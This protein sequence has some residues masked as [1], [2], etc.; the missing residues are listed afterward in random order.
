MSMREGRTGIATHE[1][2]RIRRAFYPL[3][4]CIAALAA[5]PQPAA[6]T[7]VKLAEG[8]GRPTPVAARA[9]AVAWSRY[10]PASGRFKLVISRGGRAAEARIKSRLVP[11]DVDLGPDLAGKTVAV[12][13]RCRTEPRYGTFLPLPARSTGRGCD[14]YKYNLATQRETR[15]DAASQRGASEYAPSVWGDRLAFASVRERGRRVVRLLWR[16]MRSGQAS[17]PLPA[18]PSGDLDRMAPEV[19]SAD[20]YGKRLAFSWR[21]ASAG[22]SSAQVSSVRLSTFAGKQTIIDSGESEGSVSSRRYGAAFSGTRVIYLQDDVLPS[23]GQRYIAAFNCVS[24]AR[25]RV[26]A[27]PYTLVVAASTE[28][29]VFTTATGFALE[30]ACRISGDGF[31]CDVIEEV[32]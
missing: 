10:D 6:A 31:G 28:G 15:V 30:E 19:M 26:E 13:S 23:G 18:G 21:Y 29:L 22:D 11:F 3:V 25:T 32:P 20:L 2:G 16:S 5:F 12:Y 24:E 4:I 7:A 14:I 8:L 1:T 17:R 9:D 27:N